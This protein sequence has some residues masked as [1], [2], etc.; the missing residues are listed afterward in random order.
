MR[1][2]EATHLHI[3]IIPLDQ[4]ELASDEWGESLESVEAEECIRQLNIMSAHPTLDR[5]DAMSYFL[6]AYKAWHDRELGAYSTIRQSII[7]I[8]HR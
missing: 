6:T 5:Y 1:L 3:D 7:Q 4:S 2:G 8:I